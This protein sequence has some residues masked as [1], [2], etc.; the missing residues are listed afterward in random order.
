MAKKKVIKKYEAKLDSKNRLTIR[1]SKFD[2]YSVNV[3][4]NGE[5]VLKPRILLDPNNI[6]ASTLKTIEKS[7][8]NLKK[9]KVGKVFEPNEFNWQNEQ[10]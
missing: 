9:G 2:H 4:D 8:A 7:M 6:D 10:S 1:E 5:I 3:M